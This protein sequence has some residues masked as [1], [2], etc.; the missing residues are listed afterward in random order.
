MA[1]GLFVSRLA[2]KQQVPISPGRTVLDPAAVFVPYLG[3]GLC[4]CQLPSQLTTNCWYIASRMGLTLLLQYFWLAAS[5]CQKA[6]G[7]LLLLTSTQEFCR[8]VPSCI[9]R[10]TAPRGQAIPTR[11]PRR[12]LSRSVATS[13]DHTLLSYPTHHS[14]IEV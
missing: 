5:R 3:P 14:R 4:P 11:Q 9:Y 8:D 1:A 12:A 6:V 13:S 10:S 7:E 2:E